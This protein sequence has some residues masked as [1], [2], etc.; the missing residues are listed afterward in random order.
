VRSKYLQLGIGFLLV[1]VGLVLYLWLPTA[2]GTPIDLSDGYVIINPRTEM[3]II[4]LAML[5]I[6]LGVMKTAK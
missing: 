2:F 5:L 6:G 1:I 4:G 3:G